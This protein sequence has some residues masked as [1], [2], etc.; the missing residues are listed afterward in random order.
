MNFNV[1]SQYFFLSSLS[2]VDPQVFLNNKKTLIGE[3]EHFQEDCV[4]CSDYCNDDSYEEC[5]DV[6]DYCKCNDG[7]RRNNYDKCV[8]ADECTTKQN[9]GKEEWDKIP[10][11]G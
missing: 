3:N 6:C 9:V 8:L 10:V 4:G 1:V 5:P 11:I 7:Y 2:S